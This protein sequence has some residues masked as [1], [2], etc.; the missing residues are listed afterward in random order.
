[1]KRI[2][3]KDGINSY[4]V[5]G[6]TLMEAVLAMMLSSLLVLLAL[7]AIRYY[8]LLFADIQSRGET[9]SE[10][11]MLQNALDEDARQSEQ[12]KFNEELIFI[13]PQEVIYQFQ[14][15]M[16]I[17]I[18]D[19]SVDTFSV[20]YR[21]PQIQFSKQ[22]PGLIEKLTIRCLNEKAVFPVNIIKEYPLGLKTEMNY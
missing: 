2:N 10:I 17:R 21:Y 8:T 15:E 19:L 3:I 11:R 7:S 14:D 13:G 22:I 20:D 16:I 18:Q 12:I 6:F 9:Q 1:M 5:K 4:Q